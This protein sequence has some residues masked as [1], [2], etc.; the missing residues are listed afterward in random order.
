MGTLPEPHPIA[1]R[2]RAFTDAVLADLAA[3]CWRPRAWL[4]MLER[5]SRRSLEQ[6]AARPRAAAEVTALHAACALATRSGKARAWTITSWALAITHLGMLEDQP[7]LGA[8]NTL[9][10]LRANLP[11][12]LPDRPA[13]VAAIA[14]GTDLA[15]GRYSRRTGTTTLFGQQADA[16]TDAAV[17]TW[18]ALRHEPSRALKLATIGGWIAVVGSVTAASFAKGGM[19]D[20]PR[21][22]FIRPSAAMQAVLT[23]RAVRRLAV[24]SR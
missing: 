3:D 18:L 23:A 24:K 15:D 12:I 8:A 16:L 21:P 14:A 10:L 5:V 1:P 2:S 17:W 6:I 4:R 11:A 9:T 7:G 22:R 19:I 20:A 13:L